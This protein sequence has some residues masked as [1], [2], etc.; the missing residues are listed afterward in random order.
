MRARILAALWLLYAAPAFAQSQGTLNLLGPSSTPPGPQITQVQQINGPVNAALA[1]KQDYLALTANQIIGALSAGATTPITVPS[2]A[3]AANALIWTN[4][5][6]F[7]C[8]TIGAVNPTG[9]GAALTG[10]TWPQIG[11]TPT[12]LGGYGIAVTGTGSAVQATSPTLT[13]P[14][15]SGGSISGA[16]VAA[17]TL[18]A[19]G[20]VTDT[21]RAGIST[22]GPLVIGA[23][24]TIPAVNGGVFTSNIT[25]PVSSLPTGNYRPR[26]LGDTIA[27]T[28]STTT[29]TDQ[30]LFIQNTISGTGPMG[31]VNQITTSVVNSASNMTGGMEGIEIRSDNSGSESE[32]THLLLLNPNLSTGTIGQITGI[33]FEL[34]NNNPSAGAITT[35]VGFWYPNINVTGGGSL[36]TNDYAIKIDDANSTIETQ[37]TLLIGKAGTLPVGANIQAQ[38]VAQSAS[39][40]TPLSIVTP[41]NGVML[42]VNSNGGNG[43]VDVGGALQLGGVTGSTQCLQASSTGIVTGT[44]SACGSGGGAV[45][46]VANS[47][48][49]L[50]ISPSTGA[51]VASL[52]LAHANTWTAPQTISTASGN[53][54]SINGSDTSGGTFPLVIKNSAGANMFFVTD[55]GAATVGGTLIV[56]TSG[57]AAGT[58]SFTNATSGFINV[59]A[60]TGALGSTQL[61]LPDT[62]TTLAGLAVA[63]TF[64]AA[65]TFSGTATFSLQSGTAATF[66]CFTAAGLL[67]SSATACP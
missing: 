35:V 30:S 32:F 2:C 55:S 46:S 9:S 13:T 63:Q 65:Q 50:T 42:Q 10:L 52:N 18:S 3:G 38:I 40:G 21:S 33:E 22:A 7:G 34:S 58:V 26:F 19:T 43:I 49:T 4:G 12:T 15:I 29:A 16:A 60:P 24:V 27:L 23:P 47:D 56:G 44:G 36:P 11:S 61:T 31:E 66:A 67:M 64:S 51:V 59:I 20:G 1:A 57:T 28:G 17:T 48:S 14:T 5:S 53:S 62:T 45:A 6:G 54:L 41:S 25:V 39:T 37:G 8:N